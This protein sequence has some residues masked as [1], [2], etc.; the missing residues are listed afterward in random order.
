MN[1]YEELCVDMGQRAKEA[2]YELAQIDQGAL[3]RALL[4]IADSLEAHIDEV[5]AANSKDLDQ[6]VHYDVPQTMLDRLTLTPERIAQMALGI[7]QVAELKSPVG[8]LLETIT[9]PNGLRIEKRAVPFGVIG[10][11]FE[12]RP[13]VTVDAG[14]LCLKTSNA[15]IL[16]GGKEAFNTNK[17]IVSLMRN[18]LE[19]QGITPDAVQLVEVLDR[20]MVGALLEQRQYID[21]IIPR[22]GAGLIRRV[23]NESKIPVIETGSGICHT[24]VDEYANLDMAVQIAV[25]AKVQRP[26]VCNAME[27]L[28]V[29]KTVADEF[30]PR[31]QDALESYKVR[32]HGDKDVS[33]YMNH[34]IPLE[35]ISFSTEYNDLDLNVRIVDSLAEAI[36]HINRYTTHHSEAIIT[37]E[38][39]RATVFMNLVDCSTVYHNASTRFTDG[40]EFGFG[41]EIGISTQKLHARGPMGLQ[42]LTSYK[43]F[44]F[45]EGQVR[46]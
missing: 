24:F 12:A 7:R 26:S 19:T 42:A 14:V 3:D 41:A 45:G 40:F 39:M 23:V 1:Q 37:D 46:S 34:T 25:N 15:T 5:M 21:V 35:D 10:I 16:R 32:I 22:G 2:S 27:T 29:H 36:D 6:S 31:L 18:T 20:D 9:R 4:A 30:L 43:Y 44:V 17:V 11:I 8:T 38:P 28:L 13:N 33:K